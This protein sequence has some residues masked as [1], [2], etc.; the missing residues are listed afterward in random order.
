MICAAIA[1]VYAL[2]VELFVHRELKVKDVGGVCI[3]TA[4]MIGSLFLIL[5]I[6]ISLNKLLVLLEVPQYATETMLQYTTSPLT[7][8][9]AVNIFLLLLGCVMDIISAI[10]IVAPLLAPI[11]AQYGIHP[12]HFGIM[13]IVNLELGYLRYRWVLTYLASTTFERSLVQVIRSIISSSLSCCSA[14]CVIWIPRW[15]QSATCKFR[16]CRRSRT[17][18]DR[19]TACQ[20]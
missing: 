4:S 12:I 2:F 14:Y 8:L 15:F 1:V 3:E 16:D 10:L 9:I 6:A 17:V 18:F 13:F 20:P 7:F 11:A 19:R 5:V